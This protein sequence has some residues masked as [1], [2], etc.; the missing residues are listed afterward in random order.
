MILPLEF[1]RKQIMMYRLNKREKL[2]E[3]DGQ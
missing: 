2:E 3:R 1:V